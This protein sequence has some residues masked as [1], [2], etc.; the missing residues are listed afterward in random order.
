MKKWIVLIVLA[1]LIPAVQVSAQPVDKKTFQ[2][3][4]K[5]FRGKKQAPQARPQI[6]LTAEPATAPVDELTVNEFL[7]KRKDLQKQVIELEFD[8]AI[9]LKQVGK[10]YSVRV[11][12]ESLRATE[13]VTILFA[14]DGLEFFEPLADQ[15]GRGSG[16]RK[17]VY[18]QVLPNGATVGLGTRY[19]KNKPEGERYRW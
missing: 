12:F 4:V 5:K 11:T 13:G 17:S 19:S 6:D 18:V 16:N 15:I 7:I 8:R 3:R 14:S 9:D 2:E 1:G 10:G